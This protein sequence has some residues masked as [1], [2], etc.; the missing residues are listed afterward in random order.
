MSYTLTHYIAFVNFIITF[1]NWVA[2]FS[3]CAYCSNRIV[4]TIKHANIHKRSILILPHVSWKCIDVVGY[5]F[6]PNR[7]VIKH[8]TTLHS[9]KNNL[10]FGESL[11]TKVLN[12]TVDVPHRESIKYKGAVSPTNEFE[13][14][15]TN[16]GSLHSCAY[17]L[18]LKYQ[19]QSRD[20]IVPTH[21]QGDRC[22]P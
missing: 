15:T 5:C 9:W 16:V 8:R 4:N 21:S 10:S 2:W 11:S 22:G 17:S 20:K 13:R 18:A 1:W 19:G 3:Y 7:F 6:I 14:R 12:T